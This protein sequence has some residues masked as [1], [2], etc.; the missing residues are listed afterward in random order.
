[1]KLAVIEG[2]WFRKQNTS[3]RGMFDLLSDIL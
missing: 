1:M 3:V 2:K